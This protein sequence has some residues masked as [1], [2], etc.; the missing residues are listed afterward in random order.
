VVNFDGPITVIQGENGTGKTSLLEA[1]HYMCYM[2]S[3]RTHTA[4]DLIAFEADNFFS[5][6]FFE[7]GCDKKNDHLDCE[8]QIGFA[9][10]RKV[11]KLNKKNI[12]SF[13]ELMD[14]YR[15]VTLTEDDLWII[16]GGPDVRRA[17]LDHALLLLEPDFLATIKEFKRVLEQRNSLLQRGSF[18]TDQYELW[19][20]QLWEKS[21]KMQ[22]KRQ[23]LVKMYEKSVNKILADI[24]DKSFEISFTYKAKNVDLQD[25][26]D[27][28][29][30]KMS[31][32]AHQE[33]RFCRSLFGAHLDDFCVDFQRK[34][35]KLYASRGQQKLIVL[36]LKVAQIQHLEKKKGKS[37]FLLD[38][39]FTDFDEKKTAIL[40]KFLVSLECQLIF[41][42]PS[43]SGFFEDLLYQVG[44]CKVVLEQK[45]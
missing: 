18:S 1:L 40:V 29:M 13:K 22:L 11:V 33:A 36:L 16:K 12:G 6:V 9:Q 20:M 38:D 23:K 42:S 41:T 32:F 3:F 14:F 34:K 27:D 25:T 39:F 21:R 43:Q 37:V 24:F 7:I 17:F 5:K 45:G 30:Q 26:L 31:K 15:I 2:R 28:F 44:A 10:K 35:S 8:L 4:R 19:T